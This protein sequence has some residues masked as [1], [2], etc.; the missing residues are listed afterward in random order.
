MYLSQLLQ[1]CLNWDAYCFC[2][3]IFLQL[4]QEYITE[5]SDP[6]LWRA[7]YKVQQV[8]Y[9]HIRLFTSNFTLFNPPKQK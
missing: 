7:W 5:K 4:I 8:L 1:I 6:A 9:E 2:R 3:H